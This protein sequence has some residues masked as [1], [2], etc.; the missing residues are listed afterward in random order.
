MTYKSRTYIYIC[1]MCV[2]DVFR[3]RR[4]LSPLK[5][6]NDSRLP[7]QT[8]GRRAQGTAYNTVWNNYV[9]LTLP[10]QCVHNIIS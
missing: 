7:L 2:R 5:M 9:Y 6:F 10:V 4:D 3:R 8:D 1:N